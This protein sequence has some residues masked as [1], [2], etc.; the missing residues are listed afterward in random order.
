MLISM[1][2]GFFEAVN[3]NFAEFICKKILKHNGADNFK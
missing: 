3:R 2:V 1:M